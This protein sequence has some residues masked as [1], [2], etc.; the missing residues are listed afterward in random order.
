MQ[1]D[2]IAQQ[3]A[4]PVERL[5]LPHCGHSPHRDQRDAVLDACAAF[6][7]RRVRG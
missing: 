6:L 5:V 7:T 3:V 4:G 1:I 2:A